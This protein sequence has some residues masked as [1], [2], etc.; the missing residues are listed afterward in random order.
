MTRRITI[1]LDDILEGA[2][3]EA[4]ARLGVEDDASDAERLRGYARVGYEHTLEDELDEAR[5][6][7]YRSWADER[8]MGTVARAASRRAAARGVYGSS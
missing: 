8:E 3:K 7:T 2:L 5:L 6:A 4:P 1:S